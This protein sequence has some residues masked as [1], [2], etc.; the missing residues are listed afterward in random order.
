MRDQLILRVVDMNDK[1]R[2]ASRGGTQH[3]FDRIVPVVEELVAR[4]AGH[5]RGGGPTRLVGELPA[6]EHQYLVVDD[7]YGTERR[8]A[9]EV[10]PSLLTVALVEELA[11]LVRWHPGWSILLEAGHGA[12][13]EIGNSEVWIRGW[14]TLD[15]SLE[16][17]LR[18]IRSH[19]EDVERTEQ[20]H[21]VERLREVHEKTASVW[22]AFSK[23]QVELVAHFD[24]QSNGTAGTSMWLLHFNV[25]WS[26]DLDDLELE[27]E[28]L[29]L[30]VLAVNESGRIKEYRS[31]LH[32][33]ESISGL[34]VEW[35]FVERGVPMRDVRRVRVGNPSAG[36]STEIEL[37]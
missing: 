30:T 26:I 27:P 18:E 1:G 20:V 12:S 29:R 15:N 14:R 19:L 10:E 23:K 17:Q 6:K 33:E 4:H 28:A 16:T 37:S 35:V 31:S 36:W 32:K 22:E 2:L 3:E 24:T 5:L 34:L 25:Q 8:V 7:W 13:L 11:A 9:V 21:Y